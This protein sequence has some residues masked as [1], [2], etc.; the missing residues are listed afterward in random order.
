[1]IKRSN[2]EFILKSKW[3]NEKIKVMK[4]HLYLV[5]KIKTSFSL[6][7]SA[8]EEAKNFTKQKQMAESDITAL[9]LMSI[10]LN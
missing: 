2:N 3:L 1:M 7:Q 8:T 9:P 5:C 10:F 4:L 6:Q